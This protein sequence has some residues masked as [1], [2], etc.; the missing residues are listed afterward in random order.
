MAKDSTASKT[1]KPRMR[2]LA[3]VVI[4]NPLQ[5]RTGS[6]PHFLPVAGQPNN[7]DSLS[8]DLDAQLVCLDLG[9]KGKFYI[10]FAKVK[11]M[12]FA[13]GTPKACDE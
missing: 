1:P 3:E 2:N 6:T 4:D 7:F 11:Y 12:R 5:T 8:A 10:P 13:M 9:Q